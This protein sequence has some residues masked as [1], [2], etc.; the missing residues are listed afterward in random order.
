MNPLRSFTLLLLLASSLHGQ[1]YG[2]KIVAAVIVS[3]AGTD[4]T[5][6]M[7]A[8]AEVIRN[9]AD[10]KGTTMLVEV[11]RKGQFTPV[12]QAGSSDALYL[13]FRKSHVYREALRIARLAYNTPDKLPG[14][15]N[16]ATYFHRTNT[17][18]Y[19]AKGMNLVATVGSHHFYD[20]ERNQSKKSLIRTRKLCLQT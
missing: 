5:D 6:S 17:T 15:A 20:P 2:Q 10:A 7:I 18:P 4:G 11:N 8:V 13:K 12:V 14:L 19:W 3:E 9:R 16:G 1:T